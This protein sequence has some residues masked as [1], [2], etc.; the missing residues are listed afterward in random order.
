MRPARHIASFCVLTSFLCVSC[1]TPWSNDPP[2]TSCDILGEHRESSD[3]D[4][5]MLLAVDLRAENPSQWI[6]R[7]VHAADGERYVLLRHVGRCTVRGAHLFDGWSVAEVERQLSMLSDLDL[8]EVDQPHVPSA[9][10]PTY[11]TISRVWGPAAHGYRAAVLH[12]WE[13]GGLAVPT[14]GARLHA[15]NLQGASVFRWREPAE[16]SMLRTFD[17]DDLP[18]DETWELVGEVSWDDGVVVAYRDIATRGEERPRVDVELVST[19]GGELVAQSGFSFFR[20]GPEVQIE[21]TR[22]LIGFLTRRALVGSGAAIEF[23]VSGE[24]LWGHWIEMIEPSRPGYSDY[25]ARRI[26][27]LILDATGGPQ[28]VRVEITQ[29]L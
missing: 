5:F 6:G 8:I 22:Y 1:A 18:C 3:R 27:G 20:G 24:D 25:F 28:R 21:V 2:E 14:A 13:S 10:A 9:D 7:T 17:P 16:S 4:P 23:T 12:E 19:L 15:G 11:L 29:D 26:G